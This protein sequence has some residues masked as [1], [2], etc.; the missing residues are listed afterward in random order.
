MTRVSPDESDFSIVIEKMP[1]DT[2]MCARGTNPIV[3]VYAE[4]VTLQLRGKFAAVKE[5]QVWYSNMTVDDVPPASAPIVD[6]RSNCS[7]SA[8]RACACFSCSSR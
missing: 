8:I 2:S 7:S 5:L 6:T 1:H 4:K 3:P